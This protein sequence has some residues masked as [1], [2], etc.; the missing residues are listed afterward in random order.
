MEDQKISAD[1]KTK[2]VEKLAAKNALPEA[3]ALENR[4]VHEEII[5]EVKQEEEKKLEAVG[6]L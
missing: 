1:I 4:N 6:S 2:V 5:R 3:K